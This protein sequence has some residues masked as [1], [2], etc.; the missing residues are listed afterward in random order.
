ML[1]KRRWTIFLFTCL[2]LFSST[3]ARHIKTTRRH[4]TVK[5]LDELRAYFGTFQ[6]G[7]NYNERILGHGTGLRPPTE[8]E[9]DKISSAPVRL[10]H[11][12][13]VPLELPWMVDNAA[14]PWF[15]PIGDQYSEGSCI[16]WA[17]GYYVKTFQEAREHQWDLS[18]CLWNKNDY[19]QP[20]PSYHAKIFSPDFIYHQ[21]NNGKDEGATFY[22]AMNL[23]E[24][25]GSA[26]WKNMPYNPFNSNAWP[27]E[28][29]WREAPLYRSATAFSTTD[30]TPDY[31]LQNLKHLL[32]NQN[33][34]LIAVNAHYYSK[35]SNNDLWTT[36]N[37][38]AT[39]VNHANVIVGYD[40]NFGPYSENGKSNLRGAFKIANSWGVGTYN[41]EKV[42]D[43]FY[44]ISY[45]C[46]KERIKFYMV[47]QNY[48]NYQPQLISVFGMQHQQRGQ[49]AIS[50]EV[51]DESLIYKTKTFNDFMLKGGDS[52]FPANW[53][54]LD[55][56]EFLNVIKE[57]QHQLML[58]VQNNSSTEI[59]RV[60]YFAIEQFE[61]YENQNPER[62][63]VALQT[64]LVAAP[65]TTISLS[66][67]LTDVPDSLLL[68]SPAGGETW[69]FGSNQTISWTAK[70]F[71][72]AIKIELTRDN[73][74]SWETLFDSTLNDQSETWQVSGAASDLCKIKISNQ[75]G[76]IFDESESL[77]QIGNFGPEIQVFP[78]KIDFGI[79]KLGSFSEQCLKIFNKGNQPL[80]LLNIELE[81]SLDSS[82]YSLTPLSAFPILLESGECCSLGVY[83]LATHRNQTQNT[84]RIFCDDPD[85]NSIQIPIFGRIGA[86]WEL[87]IKFESLNSSCFLT[88]GGD[89]SASHDFD[90]GMDESVDSTRIPFSNFFIHNRDTLSRD[91]Q[92][93]CQP[94]TDRIGW[95][96]VLDESLAT[97]IFISWEPAKLP[98]IENYY[99]RLSCANLDIDMSMLKTTRIS[100]EAF[101]NIEYLPKPVQVNYEF[102]V[103]GWHLISLPVNPVNQR[104]NSILSNDIEAF[105][106]NNSKAE[107]QQVDSLVP[108]KGYWLHVDKPQ[109]LS[110]TG[111][112]VYNIQSF[113]S[114]GWHL[115]GSPYKPIRFDDPDDKPDSAIT[116]VHGWDTNKQSVIPIYPAGTAIL[117]PMKGYW[118]Y[119]TQACTL[120]MMTGPA[121]IIQNPVQMT[122][123][124]TVL[125]KMTLLPPAPP[126][127]K[128]DE[129][130]I[131]ENS[132]VGNFPNPFN[133]TTQITYLQ[134]N[135]GWLRIVIYNSLGHQVSVLKDE[136]HLPGFYKITWDGREATGK[137]V[138]SGVYYASIETPELK[139]VYKMLLLR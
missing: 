80:Y 58:K 107:Y 116:S 6:E 129:E 83:F 23:L 22:D 29:A 51:G 32:A 41:W 100:Q 46:L 15:P 106:F 85:E 48:E 69:S 111:I 76:S 97:P 121:Q 137:I 30:L 68:T 113:L 42:S 44:Y 24:R 18:N 126:A 26:S 125:K 118:M 38:L 5:E 78:E 132:P 57:N 4:L 3:A 63:H 119:A 11:T 64:P 133:A 110:I 31:A 93:W 112:P 86:Q 62:I 12:Q 99:F 14:T 117:E 98:Q 37:Y 33:L 102:Q 21:I 8:S 91:I 89:S 105:I 56:T 54:V 34:A 73:G 96:I 28:N 61:N 124:M 47:Y 95:K 25:I 138:P 27:S 122:P 115:V 101:I 104:V 45:Q 65:K 120:N 53:M 70:N 131:F 77:F 128:Q 88:I 127:L 139:K 71:N 17:C 39:D 9:W 36:D 90:A 1:Q 60:G 2:V 43:G 40:D 84:L 66:V 74:N 130:V 135:S 35:L 49:C 52:P 16:G 87:P 72:S 50:V 20:D 103:A 94:Y 92:P 55:I 79:V 19:G 10:E 109:N 123:M 136:W 82:N 108:N 13:S 134:K 75:D 114:P 7:K 81:N 67:E 59:A